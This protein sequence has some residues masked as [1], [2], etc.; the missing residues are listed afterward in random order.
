MIRIYDAERNTLLGEITDE[1]LQFLMDQLE[2]ESSDDQDYFISVDTIDM[3]EDEGADEGLIAM[4][5]D[6]VGEGDGDGVDVRWERV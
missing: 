5:R 3:L 1:Q 2:E 4:L 6:A